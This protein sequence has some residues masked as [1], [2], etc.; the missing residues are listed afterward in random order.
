MDLEKLPK[1]A[2]DILNKY[3][4]PL[5]SNTPPEL[6]LA[7]LNV[8]CSRILL[9]NRTMIQP[10]DED[11]LYPSLYVIIFAESGVGKNR[12]VNFIKKCYGEVEGYHIEEYERLREEVVERLYIKAEKLSQK[13]VDENR[14][15]KQ[16][17]KTEKNAYVER[18]MPRTVTEE[19]SNGTPEGLVDMRL[20]FFNLKKDKTGIGSVHFENDEIL[21][22]IKTSSS[23]SQ[24]DIKELLKAVA[25]D[26]DN[27]T[28][29]IKGE[30]EIV[31]VKNVP[32]TLLAFSSIAKLLENGKANAQLEEFLER[33]LGRRSMLCYPDE[34]Y[35]SKKKTYNEHKEQKKE[36][37]K[38]V[39]TL[40]DIF[41]RLH[42]Y[43]I[44][45]LVP[46]EEEK[47]NKKIVATNEKLDRHI[48]DYQQECF[49]RSAQ[50]NDVNRGIFGGVINGH[51]RKSL[52]LAGVITT[53]KAV[54]AQKK[55]F[56]MTI[57][58]YEE[59]RYQIEFYF[60]QYFKFYNRTGTTD[61]EHLYNY[62]IE[63]QGKDRI[64]KG[65]VRKQKFARNKGSYL[66]KWLD[67]VFDGELEEYCYTKKKVVLPILE[68]SSKYPHYRIEDVV[69]VENSIEVSDIPKA[70]F[71][72][73]DSTNGEHPFDGFEK[74]EVAFKDI[75][76]MVQK[77][78]YTTHWF[79][80]NHRS[81]ENTQFYGN[82][83]IIDIDNDGEEK[84]Y[85]E[86]ANEMVKDY[87]AIVIPSQNHQ[88]E[89]G[90]HGVQDRY[91]IILLCDSVI[92][93]E[94]DYK[95]VMNKCIES[96]GLKGYEDTSVTTDKSRYLKR[97][98]KGCKYTLHEGNKLFSWKGFD[99]PQNIPKKYVPTKEVEEIGSIR[100]IPLSYLME[101]VGAKF[102]KKTGNN[103]F[104][105][106]PFHGGSGT[107]LRV[108]ET[109]NLFLCTQ[110]TPNPG[111]ETL[112]GTP[113]DLIMKWKGVEC[114]KAI[115]MLKNYLLTNS[116]K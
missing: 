43:T 93:P 22:W 63:N 7:V 81:K 104:Y 74:K 86:Q 71:S 59:A 109:K 99:K 88:K 27:G 95:H 35:Q 65:D 68:G 18:Y 53:V 90:E 102:N 105:Y 45:E 61:V 112:G 57:E 100:E 2:Q 67:E 28:K 10:L 97:S 89:K 60:D 80:N 9:H 75:P 116:L 92:E 70:L 41:E 56:I 79:K 31:P 44:R 84:L 91:R 29:L 113:V 8:Y 87:R 30:K 34:K 6:L 42:T 54:L 51:P 66:T 78:A 106:C 21:D 48:F 23:S 15:D 83:L 3:L 19:F 11:L 5:S 47:Y 108:N 26:G 40:E 115:K 77:S 82:L 76:E 32:Q 52:R 14:R 46:D 17:S 36:A 101:E 107:S 62:I 20:A 33:G 38:Y 1:Y 4:I 13:A 103:L 96:L 69:E 98:P 110:C 55:E 16:W 58:D 39:A 12:T 85:I 72:T 37:R 114:G 50:M 25:E 64:H 94:N 49:E 73:S 111:Y 24:T